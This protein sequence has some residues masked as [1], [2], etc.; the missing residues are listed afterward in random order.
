M[1]GGFGPLS[2]MDLDAAINEV[3]YRHPHK[4]KT[5]ADSFIYGVFEMD[6]FNFVLIDSSRREE[7]KSLWDDSFSYDRIH[8]YIASVAGELNRTDSGPFSVKN[9]KFVDG[10]RNTVMYY[11]DDDSAYFEFSLV[12]YSDVSP[13]LPKLRKILKRNFE[14]YRLKHTSQVVVEGTYF[15]RDY[16]FVE[17]ELTRHKFTVKV[18]KQE[19]TYMTLIGK[20]RKKTYDDK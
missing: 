9:C 20:F 5:L 10:I 7:L 18:T 1:E 8:D 17:K 11:E 2:A 14:K 19:L 12:D 16:S 13:N 6:D 3:L 15:G 4:K